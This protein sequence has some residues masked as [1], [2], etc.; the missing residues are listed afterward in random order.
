MILEVGCEMM[1]VENDTVDGSEIRRTRR[2]VVSPIN[3]VLYRWC[4]IFP[5]T[6]A[7]VNKDCYV[8]VF[9]A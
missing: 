9:D 3:K 7:C 1:E 6:V 4:R 5:S 2:L 8:V